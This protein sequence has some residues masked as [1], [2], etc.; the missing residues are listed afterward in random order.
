MIA[1]RLVLAA[2]ALLGAGSAHA[3]FVSAP[4]TTAYVG[5]PYVY[6]ITAIG[7]ESLVITAPNGLPPWLRLQQTGNGTATLSGTPSAGDSG[8]GILLRAEDTACRVFLILCYRYQLFDITII[9]NTPPRVVAPGIADQSAVEGT[10]FALDVSTAFEDTDGDTLRLAAAGLPSSFTFAGGAISGTPS[11]ADVEGSPYSVRIAADDGRGGTV[12]ETFQI[13]IS[14]LQRADLSIAAIE[15][16]PSPALP[17]ASVTWTITVENAGPNASGTA[18][19]TVGLAG[20]AVSLG[21][22]DCTVEAL[23]GGQR[24]VCPLEPLDGGGSATVTFTATA[25]VPG[26]VFVTAAVAGTGE[27]PIDPVAGNDRASSALNVGETISAEPAQRI[28]DP[29]LA[30]AAADLDGDG[31]DDLIVATAP[32]VPA[33]LHLSIEN[34]TSLH[35]ALGDSLDERR[36][37]STLPLSL[38]E[39]AANTGAAIADFDADGDLDAVVANGAGT[40][41]RLFVN[42]GAGALGPGAV[43]GAADVATRHVAAADVDG[44]GFADV[45]FANVG[46]NTLYL[47]RGGVSFEAV[48][49][50]DAPRVSVDVAVTDLDGD[51][52]PDAAFAN[53]DGDATQHR[54]TGSGLGPAST[55][56]TGPTAAVEAGDLNGDSFADLVFARTVPGPS[57]LPSNP[58]YLNDGAGAF[59]LAAELGASPTFDVLVTDLNGDGPLDIVAI[60]ATGAHQV[61]VNDGSGGFAQHPTLFLA[62]GATAGAAARIG[63][64]GSMDVVAVG[65]EGVALFLNDGLGQLGLGDTGRPVIELI[66]ATEISLEVEQPYED[67]GA[68]ATDDV[69]G[70]LTPTVDNPVDTKLIGTYVV[71]YTAKDSA[72]NAAMPV[73]RTVKVEAHEAS[74][75]GGGGAADALLLAL[76]GLGAALTRGALSPRGGARRRSAPQSTRSIPR[77]AAAG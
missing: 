14:A 57:G 16:S 3:E 66:G 75:G 41:G 18:A 55:L 30:A 65:E 51:A 23:D 77:R 9:Q 2:A 4:V 1:R 76:L 67:P 69:D 36:G 24:L 37:L 7:G 33:A 58:V 27:R 38:G 53:E 8:A 31:Y 19:V 68:T 5:L 72:G 10:P 47:N 22:H 46:R 43:V 54:N 44:D 70:T 25:S 13:Q 71:T 52:R 64:R 17:G 42:D 28:G 45:V 21:E 63:I 11:S 62:R 50:E 26:D 61:F 29:G 59:T 12:E 49:L 60:N 6:D 15:A 32:D 56:A 73:T 20:N 74:G 34:P 35:P 40:E 48:S 39:A